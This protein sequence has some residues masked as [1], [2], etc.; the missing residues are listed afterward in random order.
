MKPFRFTLEALRIIRE[1]QESEAMEKY[2]RALM[3]LKRRREALEQ[4]ASEVVWMQEE[5]KRRLEE[6]SMVAHIMHQQLS[7]VHLEQVRK[8]AGEAVDAAGKEVK[9]ALQAM[10]K[11]RRNREIVDKFQARQRAVYDRALTLEE[12]KLMDELASHRQPPALSWKA[13]GYA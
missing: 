8:E 12:Q 2:G 3:E 1:R 6:G 5:I 10:L 11:A 4:A 13:A 7:L 9:E